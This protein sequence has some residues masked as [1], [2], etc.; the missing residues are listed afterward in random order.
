VIIGIDLGTTYSVAAYMGNNGEISVVHDGTGEYAIP[1]VIL[2]DNGRFVVGNAAKD[3]ASFES[4]NVK[5][6]IKDRMGEDTVIA[7]WGGKEYDPVD[8]SAEIIKH[9]VENAKSCSGEEITG[10][11]VTVPAYFTNA[12]RIA[13]KK[14]VD[15]AGIEP[16]SII[17]EPTAAA[18]CYVHKNKISDEKILVYDLGGGT[19]DVSIIDV[20]D[21]NS[22][23]V[24]ST[25]GLKKAGGHFF[26]EDVIKEIAK[27][28]KDEHGID[29][30]DEEYSDDLEELRGSI[31]KN[32][33]LLAV[34]ESA[35]IPLRFGGF[36]GQYMFTRDFFESIVA[37]TYQRTEAKCKQAIKE[38]GLTIADIDRILLCNITMAHFPVRSEKQIKLKLYQGILAQ[39]MSS[40]HS[41]VAFHW[42]NMFEDLRR[43]N[44]EFDLIT[45]SKEYALVEEN[46]EGIQ[47]K[48]DRLK[49]DWCKHNVYQKYTKYIKHDISDIVFDIAEVI[50]IRSIVGNE[51]FDCRLLIYGAGRGANTL[52]DLLFLRDTHI[53]AYIDSD[54]DKE[55]TTYNGRVVLS[56]EKI[57]YLDFDKILISCVD[58]GSIRNKLIGMGIEE[59]RIMDKK[60]LFKLVLKEQFLN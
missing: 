33:K 58:E 25:Q 32:K 46:L 29:I 8:L 47:Y 37:K 48:N 45:Y 15:M 57:K 40:Y 39:L 16:I 12:Q 14:A 27:I 24:V 59:D 44:G 31:E 26:D 56:P 51:K 38:A 54:P 28:C 41:V 50:A 17:N 3:A 55:Y 60:Q 19:F 42:K 30:F 49:Y 35:R 10:A 21:T 53:I 22:I 34:Y 1:S 9:M 11:V 23:E 36:K 6:F 4:E 43:D 52:S 2:W 5:S 20:K 13:T 18:L 7:N